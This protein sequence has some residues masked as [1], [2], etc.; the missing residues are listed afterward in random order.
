M[1]VAI[2]LTA[3]IASRIHVSA[4]VR[5]GARLSW[6]AAIALRPPRTGAASGGGRRFW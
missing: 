6:R 3:R 1:I 5:S 4:L 2:G